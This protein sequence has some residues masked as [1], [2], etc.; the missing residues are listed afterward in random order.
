MTE[1]FNSTQVG[2]WHQRVENL[3]QQAHTI[4][5]SHR[6]Q[7]DE[8]AESMAQ[9]RKPE[10]GIVPVDPQERH[11]FK[12]VHARRLNQLDR[13]IREQSAEAIKRLI[14]EATEISATGDE[15]LA[16][17]HPDQWLARRTVASEKRG[18]YTQTLAAVGARELEVYA[19]QANATGDFDLA[20]AVLSRS[21][22]FERKELSLNM[23]EFIES[24]PFPDDFTVARDKL[25]A[26]KRDVESLVRQLSQFQ[27]TG[28]PSAT[29][30]EKI[31]RGL[32]KHRRE[33]KHANTS[34]YGYQPSA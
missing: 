19:T 14:R 24:L 9:Q 33:T 6:N 27:S 32:A 25:E 11:F 31:A 5:D 13:D 15:Q 28:D 34:I 16:H 8:F 18:H 1:I 30:L 4:F 10:D 20:A 3:K 26:G 17:Y 21:S 23:A 2:E 29:P 22:Q 12:N 7:L